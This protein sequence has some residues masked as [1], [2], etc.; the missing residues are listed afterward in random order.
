MTRIL[1]TGCGDKPPKD[2]VVRL[3]KRPE[4]R[5]DVIWDL[6][7]F[8]YPFENSTFSEIECFDVIEHLDNI[9]KTMEEFHRILNPNGL[10][11]IA[12]PHFSCANSYIDVTHKWHLSYFSFDF[13]HNKYLPPHSCKAKFHIRHRHLQFRGLPFARQAISRLAN[14]FPRAYEDRW[15]WIFPAWFIYFELEAMK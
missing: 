10:V 9:P 13:F 15:A 11:K 8:P 2:G 12:T 4:V 14:F 3:D 1:S 5:P 6:N 7:N